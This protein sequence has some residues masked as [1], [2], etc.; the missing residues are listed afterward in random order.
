MNGKS[1]PD[2][3]LTQAQ[4]N[5]HLRTRKQQVTVPFHKSTVLPKRVSVNPWGVGRDLKLPALIVF[6]NE[7]TFSCYSFVRDSIEQ[8]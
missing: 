4:G 3:K 6:G 1:I 7:R 2:R 5:D 8:G